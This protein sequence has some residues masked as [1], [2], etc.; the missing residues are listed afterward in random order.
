MLVP[1]C[2][3]VLSRV[4][5]FP[6]LSPLSEAW[7]EVGGRGKKKERRWT[8]QG[9]GSGRGLERAERAKK[10][11]DVARRRVPQ[12]AAV[13]ITGLQEGFSYST[14]LKDARSKI[15]LKELVLKPLKSGGP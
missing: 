12:S 5:D 10:K 9:E 2:S 15:N 7:T 13:T 3:D 14:A 1:P 6:P 4:R 8:R 11:S